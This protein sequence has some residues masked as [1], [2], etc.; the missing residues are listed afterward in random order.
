MEPSTSNITGP[1]DILPWLILW[2]V[3]AV[4]LGIAGRSRNIGFLWA[5]L[6]SFFLTPVVGLIGVALSQRKN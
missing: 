3:L 2:I 4:L 6:L 1:G 5:F